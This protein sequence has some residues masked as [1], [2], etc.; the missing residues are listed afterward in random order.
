[1]NRLYFESPSDARQLLSNTLSRNAVLWFLKMSPVWPINIL[2]VL[3]PQGFH[4]TTGIRG[5]E[6]ILQVLSIEASLM[7]VLARRAAQRLQRGPS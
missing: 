2:S 1:M 5:I 3:M 7:S 4:L 6:L